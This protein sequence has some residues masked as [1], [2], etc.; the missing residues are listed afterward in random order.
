MKHNEDYLRPLSSASL[1]SNQALKLPRISL[2][3]LNLPT[4]RLW[5]IAIVTE[6]NRN[7]WLGTTLP[8]DN[9]GQCYSFAQLLLPRNCDTVR[10]CMPREDWN[11]YDRPSGTTYFSGYKIANKKENFPYVCVCLCIS[12]YSIYAYARRDRLQAKIAVVVITVG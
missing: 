11:V 7:R 4:K 9:A 3:V 8:G 5:L 2:T 6:W 10:L 12:I 1:F